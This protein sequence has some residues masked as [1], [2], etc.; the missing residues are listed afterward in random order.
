[1]YTCNST[2]IHPENTR[3]ILNHQKTSS[4]PMARHP[5]KESLNK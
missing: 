4:K 3:E 2:T 5:V 1:M